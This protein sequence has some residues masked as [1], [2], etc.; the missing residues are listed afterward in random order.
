MTRKEA[1]RILRQVAKS[2]KIEITFSKNIKPSGYA[3]METE[4]IGINNRLS[5]RETFSTVFHEICHI[6]NKREGKYPIFHNPKSWKN[7]GF[8]PYF[9]STSHRA[10]LFTEKR[11][12]L[13]MKKSF[14]KIKYAMSYFNTKKSKKRLR[15]Y[16]TED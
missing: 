11:A 6:L 1:I 5:I 4:H 8:S 16:F 15:D 13:L 10:E 3:N 14:P 9:L 2:Y 12:K 7:N